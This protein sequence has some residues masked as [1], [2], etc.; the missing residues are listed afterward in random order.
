MAEWSNRDEQ[1]GEADPATGRR[2]QLIAPA[3][4]GAIAS[5]QYPGEVPDRST[6]P[7]KFSTSVPRASDPRRPLSEAG[8]AQEIMG[9]YAASGE[10][11]MD[12]ARFEQA[13][14]AYEEM[15]KAYPARLPPVRPA[16]GYA[17][18]H[19][20]A[21]ASELQA[22]DAPRPVPAEPVVET[23][24]AALAQPG[25]ST[26]EAARTDES[27]AKVGSAFSPSD[28]PQSVRT[29]RDAAAGTAVVAES[30][31]IGG[32]D[33]AQAGPNTETP[34]QAAEASETSAN[35]PSAGAAEGDARPPDAPTR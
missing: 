9:V 2:R 30:A 7:G 4:P 11:E 12:P 23:G 29:P 14:A 25:G 19:G 17:L 3:A 24:E 31:E 33:W 10:R 6:V 35:D 13:T 1:Q 8:T 27:A 22:I 21:M 18:S 26:A 32:S 34:N 15:R 16:P 20:D 28:A 5:P